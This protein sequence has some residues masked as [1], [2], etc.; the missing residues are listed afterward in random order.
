MKVAIDAR[1]YKMSGIGT[2]IQNLIKNNCYQIAL[3]NEK[4]LENIQELEEIIGFDAP[5][6]GIKEQLKFPYKKLKELNPDILHIPHY[7]VPIFYRGDMA[8]TIHD[9]T[10]LV[11]SEFFGSKIKVLYAKI[12]M[13][14]AIK[15]ARVILTVSE[16][17]KRDIIKYFKVDKNKIKVTYL[18]LKEELIEKPKEEVEY[19]YS[20]LEIPRDKKLLM[21]VGNLKPHKNLE[22]LLIAFSKLE[23][24]EDYRLLLVRKSF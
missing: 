21:Y 24:N 13:K 8:V 16:N 23:N 19:L 20:K 10:H 22:R 3:G 7:N 17:T 12:M 11:Y 1:M 18:G 15:K 6:Y 2:Y 9:L 14:I 4:E 5:I